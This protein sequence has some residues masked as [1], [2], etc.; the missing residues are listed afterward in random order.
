MASAPNPNNQTAL[1]KCF[2]FVLLII[3]VIITIL[4]LQ[5]G[6]WLQFAEQIASLKTVYYYNLAHYTASYLHKKLIQ[7]LVLPLLCYYSRFKVH[8]TLWTLLKG[9]SPLAKVG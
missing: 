3:V 2:P 1:P 8:L 4:S 5:N 6:R 7:Y 9:N